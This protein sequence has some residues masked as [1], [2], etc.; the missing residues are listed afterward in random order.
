MKRAF[1]F[2]SVTAGLAAAAACA[3]SDVEGPAASPPDSED[4]GTTVHAPDAASSDAHADVDA[5]PEAA[6]CSGAGWCITDL[7][8]SD[9]TLR[10]V[11]PHDNHTFAIAESPT[12]G[13]KF[14]EWESASSTWRYIDDYSQN[15]DQIGHAGAM[16]SPS[17]DEVYFAVTPLKIFHGKRTVPDGSWSWSYDRLPPPDGAPAFDSVDPPFGVVGTSSGDVYAWYANTIYRRTRDDGGSDA[18]IVEYS[19]DETNNGARLSL[20][21]AAAPSGDEVWF[22]GASAFTCP[23]IIRT[24]PAEGYQ[25]VADGIKSPSTCVAR[26]GLLMLGNGVLE[27]LRVASDDGVVGVVA[28]GATRDVVRITFDASA[29]GGRGYAVSRFPVDGT[30][31]RGQP[32]NT[33]WSARDEPIWLGGVSIILRS[34]GDVFDGG[35]FGV[36]TISLNG[37]WLDFPIYKI[38]SASTNNRWAVGAKYA[39]HKTTP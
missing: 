38:R 18:W 8:D 14:L 23:V 1:S 5:S 13:V 31:A 10:D 24:S 4:S 35:S 30:L 22:A 36:S 28:N 15:A 19:S 27:E 17:E 26:D 20:R 39:L 37:A 12:L 16:W 6:T 3:S 11:W 25:R 2:A 29:D 33:L 9:L 32:I 34:N 7:P 21:T